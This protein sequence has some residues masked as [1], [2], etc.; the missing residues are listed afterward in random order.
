MPAKSRSRRSRK[1]IMKAQFDEEFALSTLASNTV[2]GSTLTDT[3][4]D[5][6]FLLSSEGVYSIQNQ[7]PGQGPITIGWSHGDFTDAEVEAFLETTQGFSPGDKVAQEIQSRGRVIRII[8]SFPS[9]AADEVLNDGRPIKTKLRFTLQS[10]ETLRLWAY[11]NSGATLAGGA[12]VIFKGHFWW[13][14]A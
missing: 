4:Q 6:L 7:T 3:A 11:N 10:T 1:R 5:K 14:G 13:V 2:L 9:I 8:G 12:S